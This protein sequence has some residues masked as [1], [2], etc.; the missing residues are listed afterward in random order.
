[1]ARI[2]LDH[3][4][5]VFADGTVGLHDF[6]LDI[7][8]REFLTFLGPSGCGKTTTLRMIAGLEDAT[9]GTIHFNDRRVDTLGPAARNVAMVFQSYALYPHMTVRGNLEY[10]LRKRKVERTEREKRIAAVADSLKIQH[11]LDRRPRQLSGGQQQRVAL[12]RAMVRESEVFLFDEPLSNLDA[13]LRAHMRTELI[14]LHQRLQR[15][16]VYVTHDQL[17]AMTMST[18]IAVLREGRLQQVGTPDDIYRK[19]ANR[20]VANFVGSPA[21]NFLEGQVRSSPNGFVFVRRGTSVP[22][23]GVP[24]TLADGTDMLAGI[25]PE[26]LTISATGLAARVEVIERTGHEALVWLRDEDQ[27]QLVIR[28]AGD[29]DLRAGE[30]VHLA[31]A[32]GRMHLFSKKDERRVALHYDR[33]QLIPP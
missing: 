18:R 24:D 23:G 31:C 22:L 33:V 12:G 11:L 10:P 9:S 28:H 1:M 2:R 20:F 15:T 25:R 26:D 7:A 19:P 27:A 17:E 14:Q 32:P 3:L 21:M 8:E 6:C 5:K 16:M 30:I 13:E 4:R 29:T